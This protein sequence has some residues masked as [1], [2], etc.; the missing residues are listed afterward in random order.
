MHESVRGWIAE[1]VSENGLATARVLE[2]G[3][4]NVNGSVRDLFSG[5]YVGL[6]MRDGPGVDV[7]GNAHATGFPDASFDVVVSTELMEHDD[8]FWETLAEIRRVLSP[9]GWLLLTTRGNGFPLHHEPD[10]L[11]RFMPGSVP[12]L[13]R[14]AGCDVVAM[15]EDPQVAGVFLAGRRVNAA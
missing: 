13:A 1:Q 4:L 11:W 8:A 5:Q 10:D 9:D 15:R 6:D 12:V 2:V 3:S 14:L 7:V